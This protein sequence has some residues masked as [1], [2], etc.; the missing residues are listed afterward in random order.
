MCDLLVC[1]CAFGW[2]WLFMVPLNWEHF[3]C[4]LLTICKT[5]HYLYIVS[6][7][8]VRVIFLQDGIQD[9]F[10]FTTF[11]LQYATY[12]FQLL[13]SLF[14]EPKSKDYTTIHD[15]EVSIITIIMIL[16][17]NIAFPYLWQRH[18]SP[19]IDASFLSRIT[20]WW[21]NELIWLGWR[22]SLIYDDLSDLKQ[23]DKCTFSSSRFQKQ[24]GKEKSW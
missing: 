1:Y 20:W 23:E 12:V 8:A 6:S 3:C 5:T 16:I 7:C 11:V 9:K 22:R 4:F 21:Q 17:S 19:E 2:G 13:F 14:Q 10:R 18:P 24:W 15:S